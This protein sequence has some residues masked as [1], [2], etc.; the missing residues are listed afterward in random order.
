MTS[1]AP[2]PEPESLRPFDPT[3]PLFASG[4]LRRRQLIS[5]LVQGGSTV[6]A[7]A[8]VAVLGIVIYAVVERGA[9]ALTLDF[10]IHN[11]PLF[12]GVGGGIL[13]A[14]VGSALI[15]A[16][17]AVIAVPLGVLCAL[18]LVEFAGPG[19]RSGGALRLALDMMQGL[20]SVVI[21]LFILGLVVEPERADSGFAG[22][23]A[24]AIIMLPLIART[25]QEVLLTIP[26]PL[27]DATDALGVDRWRS[28]LTVIL[29][30]ALSG[31]VTG[32]ILAVARAAGETAPL[33]IVDGTFTNQTTFQVFGHAV[34]NIPVLI[35]T[36]S[37][38]ANPSGF[39]RAWGAALVL[40]ALILIA[41]IGARLLLARNRRR[42][43]L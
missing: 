17:A 5:R 40:L 41:N 14:I 28:V 37:E 13:D 24:L 6:S 31:I 38:A 18:Y 36:L 26:Q 29:P 33:L 23:L 9:G 11:P 34:P 32:A 1:L 22:S 2:S 16:F 8:A 39:Q 21:G 3:A 35:F 43:G 10:F 27:R 4:N 20:P 42:M 12:G 19:S 30:S 15:V 7:L 25:T